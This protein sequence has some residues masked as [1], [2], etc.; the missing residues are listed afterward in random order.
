MA[1][2]ISTAMGGTTATPMLGDN[3]LAT[4]NAV[5][6]DPEKRTVD[7]AKETVSGQLDT[8]LKSGSPYLERAK[9]GAMGTANKR[10]LL[11]SSIAAG[12]GEAAAIDASLPIANADANVYGTASRDN[13]QAGNTALQFGAGATNTSNLASADAQNKSAL[14]NQIAGNER[15]LQELRGTQAKELAGMDAASQKELQGMR[16]TQAVDIENIKAENQLALQ[17][18]KGGQ[19][20]SIVGIENEYKNL[21]QTNTLAS[22]IYSNLLAAMTTVANSSTMDTAAKQQA[23]TNMQAWLQGGLGLIGGISGLDLQSLLDFG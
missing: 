14:T 19:A 21:L 1:G 16:G 15:T 10:G 20:E 9:A 12:A 17:E 2:L 11:N 5:G 23:V 3:Q 18:L 6:Y 22:G 8:L 4:A 13:Q 7:A